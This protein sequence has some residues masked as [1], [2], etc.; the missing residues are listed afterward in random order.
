[1]LTEEGGTDAGQEEATEA[2]D[3]GQLL[4]VRRGEKPRGKPSFPEA[5][6]RQPHSGLALDPML[7]LEQ[8]YQALT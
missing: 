2:S 3:P 1:M 6:Q 8:R 7:Q 5:H 4:R